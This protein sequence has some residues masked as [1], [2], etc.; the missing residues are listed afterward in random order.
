MRE[1]GARLEGEVKQ[2]LLHL[3]R[4]DAIESHLKALRE[5]SEKKNEHVDIKHR[6][7]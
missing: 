2:K 7:F 1:A 4:K 6:H 3:G 5:G